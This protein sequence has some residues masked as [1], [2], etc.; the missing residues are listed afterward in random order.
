MILTETLLF[1]ILLVLIY[2]GVEMTAQYAQISTLLAGV[3]KAN[4]QLVT[5]AAVLAANAA[6]GTGLTAAETQDLSDRLTA[7][8]NADLAAVTVDGG[9]SLV[10]PSSPSPAPAPAPAPNPADPQDGQPA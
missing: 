9:P 8:A 2:I 1:L 10:P 5:I 6:A 3:E 7:L 4:A